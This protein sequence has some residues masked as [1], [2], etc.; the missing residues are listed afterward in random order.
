MAIEVGEW[1][2]NRFVLPGGQSGNPFSPHYSDQLDLYRA[3]GSISIAWTERKR[4][5]VIKETLELLPA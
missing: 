5:A 3:G 2:R 4:E 1:D